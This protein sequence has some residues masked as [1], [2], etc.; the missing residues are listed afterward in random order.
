MKI[1]IKYNIIYFSVLQ[2]QL[3]FQ[4]KLKKERNIGSI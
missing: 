4:K 3:K 2:V 1:Q